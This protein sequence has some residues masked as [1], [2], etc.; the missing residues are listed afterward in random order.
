MFYYQIDIKRQKKIQYLVAS[1]IFNFYF[2]KTFS[3]TFH[4]VFMLTLLI[5]K[6][7]IVTYVYM[8]RNVTIF[9]LKERTSEKSISKLILFKTTINFNNLI[10][11]YL[12]LEQSKPNYRIGAS[13]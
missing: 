3:L 5:N 6:N 1:G 13:S 10:S 4:L 7:I 2:F 11:N 12:E 9:V 8:S